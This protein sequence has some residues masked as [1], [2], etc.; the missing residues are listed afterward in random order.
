[1]SIA[2]NRIKLHFCQSGDKNPFSIKQ[3]RN[4]YQI[5]PKKPPS[6]HTALKIGTFL[7]FR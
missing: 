2:R 1:M 3:V 6:G 5:F 4:L 7:K